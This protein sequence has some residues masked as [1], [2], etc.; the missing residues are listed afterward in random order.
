MPLVE[1]PDQT[2]AIILLIDLD[3]LPKPSIT[4]LRRAFGLTAAEARL[5]AQLGVG[6]SLQQIAHAQK[7]T[8]DTTRAHLRTVLAKTRTHRQAELVA[9]VNRLMPLP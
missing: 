3:D 8:I 4:A 7:V 2:H 6:R 1:P 9:L 5:A